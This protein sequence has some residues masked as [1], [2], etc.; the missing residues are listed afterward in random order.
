MTFV[1]PVWP[2][3]EDGP[4]VVDGPAVVD[5][6]EDLDVAAGF[7]DIMVIILL[8]SIENLSVD[9]L[10]HAVPPLSSGR[11][12]SQQKLPELHSRTASFPQAVLSNLHQYW[13]SPHEIARNLLTGC[14]DIGASW[15][16]PRLVR[17]GISAVV[18][19]IL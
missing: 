5:A 17:A 12:P 15:G 6:A 3:L 9:A 7:S 13:A 4:E 10:Q 8:P 16:I 2:W 11:D 1:D 18:I 14:A 19:L